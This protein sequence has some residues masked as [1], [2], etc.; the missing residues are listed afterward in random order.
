MVRRILLIGL[1]AAVVLALWIFASTRPVRVEVA[2]L[3]RGSVR[4]FVEE[5]G[6]TR[7][8]DRFVVSTPVLWLTTACPPALMRR[9]LSCRAGT[10]P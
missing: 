6:K 8:I 4:S 7:V 3:Q 1:P 10:S 2:K 5:E 9:T